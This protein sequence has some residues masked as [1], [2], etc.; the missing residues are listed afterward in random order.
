MTFDMATIEN[1]PFLLEMALTVSEL[2]RQKDELFKASEA[3]PSNVRARLM[4]D[5]TVLHWARATNKYHDALKAVIG[6]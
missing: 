4:Y 2:T 1:D 3:D 6:L 5:A